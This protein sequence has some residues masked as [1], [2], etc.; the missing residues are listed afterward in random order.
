MA[1][2]T[3]NF[4]WPVPTLHD[5]ATI[6]DDMLAFAKPVDAVVKGL[7]DRLEAREKIF[8][9]HAGD[10]AYSFHNGLGEPVTVV[11]GDD[12]DWEVIV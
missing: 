8:I 7:A 9:T 4:G 6:A 5:P 1:T 3:P 2:S 11:A 12:G 10:G